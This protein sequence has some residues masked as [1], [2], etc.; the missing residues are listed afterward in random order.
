LVKKKLSWKWLLIPIIAIV[1][2]VL[3]DGGYL[4]FIDL[5]DPYLP[6][7]IPEIP[8]DETV[9]CSNVMAEVFVAAPSLQNLYHEIY[10][11]DSIPS[12]VLQSYRTSLDSQGYGVY[13]YGGKEIFNST[14][15]GSNLIWYG[16][17]SKGL[18][19]IFIMAIE[20]AE[21]SCVLYTAG[22]LPDYVPV[23]EE[24]IAYFS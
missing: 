8:P 6:P 1:A 4:P 22:A 16:A 18:T 3:W 24:V 2:F 15:V 9:N 11:V 13:V 7:D 12:E 20:N 14:T 10:K 5:P 19:G 17:F 23:M 21:G